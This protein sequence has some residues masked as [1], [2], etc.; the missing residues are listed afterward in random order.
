MDS[1]LNQ[2]DTGD[3]VFYSD[4]VKVLN[5]IFGKCTTVESSQLADEVRKVIVATSN[6]VD[7]DP[8]D[9]RY[10]AAGPWSTKE[11]GVPPRR[12]DDSSLSHFSD[13]VLTAYPD[14]DELKWCTGVYNHASNCWCDTN[15]IPI[16]SHHVWY[17]AH[18]TLPKKRS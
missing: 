16:I 18:V 15:A 1:H 8:P 10:I 17:W 13:I 5:D 6:P 9:R 12:N 2:E 4:V 11:S 3:F 7:L 14:G